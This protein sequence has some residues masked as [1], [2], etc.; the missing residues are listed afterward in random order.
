MDLNTDTILIGGMPFS[1]TAVLA[2]ED[3]AALWDAGQTDNLKR[4]TRDTIRRHIDREVGD[5]QTILGATADVAQLSAAALLALLVAMEANTSFAQVR[6][7]FLSTVEAL[8]PTD[9]G[10]PTIYDHATAFLQGLQSGDVKLTAALKGFDNVIAELGQSSTAVTTILAA[11]SA[12][13]SDS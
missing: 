10:A 12:R 5:T 8:L 13:G 9:E 2:M 6:T 1:K 3:G 11:D 4:Q 7:Q